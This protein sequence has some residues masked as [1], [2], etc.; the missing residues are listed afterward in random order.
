MTERPAMESALIEELQGSDD[1]E[2]TAEVVARVATLPLDDN[3]V[4]AVTAAIREVWGRKLA[5][6]TARA[7]EANRTADALEAANK[8]PP[9]NTVH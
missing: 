5:V 9:S 3:Y 8:L 1:P 7:E 2:A 6:A 4:A